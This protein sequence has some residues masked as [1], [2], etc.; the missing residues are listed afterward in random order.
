[1]NWEAMLRLQAASDKGRFVERRG[2]EL[3]F[4]DSEE[5]GASHRRGL[6]EVG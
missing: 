6:K 1:M 2:R 5:I 3:E 4:S